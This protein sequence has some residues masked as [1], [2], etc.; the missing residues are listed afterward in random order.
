M[1][2]ALGGDVAKQKVPSD[3]PDAMCA[4]IKKLLIRDPLSRPS[5]DKE[6]LCKTI[7]DIRQKSFGRIYSGLKKIPGV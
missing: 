5:W 7:Q 4:F 1:I 6:D 2:Y 3:T